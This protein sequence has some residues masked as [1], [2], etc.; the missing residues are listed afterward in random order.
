MGMTCAEGVYA[1]RVRHGGQRLPRHDYRDGVTAVSM[2]RG[3]R[4]L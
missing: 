4:V 2:I 3:L 1:Y